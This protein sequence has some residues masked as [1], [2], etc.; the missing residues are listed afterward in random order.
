MIVDVSWL[1]VCWM[2]VVLNDLR[3]FDCDSADRALLLNNPST[4]DEG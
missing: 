3:G 1:V 2:I 4:W